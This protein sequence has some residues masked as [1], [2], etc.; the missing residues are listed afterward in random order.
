MHYPKRQRES[1]IAPHTPGEI[2][3]IEAEVLPPQRY[4]QR[5]IAPH[6]P[7]HREWNPNL[8]PFIFLGG[9]V[10]IVALCFVALAALKPPPPPPP[11]IIIQEGDDVDKSG[12][13]FLC[14]R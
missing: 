12:C 4:Q 8:T 1:A 13:L 10:T 6:Y 2:Q 9:V 11:P 3:L 14:G 5:A 7:V